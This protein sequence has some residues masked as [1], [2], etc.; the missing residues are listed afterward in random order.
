M[1]RCPRLAF[2]VVIVFIAAGARLIKAASSLASSPALGDVAVSFDSQVQV[3]DGDDPNSLVDTVTL[4]ASNAG[5][6]FDNALNLFVANTTF[7][8]SAGSI[9]R[10]TPDTTHTVT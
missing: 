3:Y 10:I 2:F 7:D 1:R 8:G 4:G 9:L 5:L 6:A